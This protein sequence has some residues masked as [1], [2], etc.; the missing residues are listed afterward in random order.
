MKAARR[1]DIG[2]SPLSGTVL[3]EASAGTGKTYAIS[4][5]YLRL[6]I[7]KRLEVEN[8][9]VVTFTVA[10]TGELREQLRGRLRATLSLMDNP[11]GDGC[12][13]ELLG[14]R[15]KYAED[16]LQIALG[17]KFS[18]DPDARERLSRAIRNF[19]EASIFTIHSFCQRALLENA[20]ESGALFEA[21]FI[22]GD[23][24]LLA[25]ISEDYYRKNFYEAPLP[26][27]RYSLDEKLSPESLASLV[28]KRPLDPGYILKGGEGGADDKEVLEAADRLYEKY[29]EINEAWMEAKAEAED[30]LCHCRNE[31]VLNGVSYSSKIITRLLENMDAYA[32]QGEPLP[33]FKD[34][35]KLKASSISNRF[36]R[37][38]SA[39]IPEIF[40]KIG[41]FL[42]CHERAIGVFAGCLLRLQREFFAYAS[43]EMRR[44]KE[45]LAVRS[46][47]DLLV[48]THRA[49]AAGS[50]SALARS[51]RR[52]YAAALI[53]EF[54]DTDPIQY[55][56]FT[57][58][59]G[60]GESLLYLIGDPKQAIYGFR[61]ADIF[62]YMKAAASAGTKS[63]MDVNYRSEPELVEA[64]NTI[65]SN[66]DRPFVFP[67]IGFTRV[68]AAADKKNRG[69]SESAR[70][71]SGPSP[72]MKLWFVPQLP[73]SAGNKPMSKAEAGRIV[74]NAVSAEIVRLISEEKCE[75]GDIAVLVRTGLQARE[76]QAALRI[77]GVPSV[78]YGSE[79]VFASNEA[80]ELLRLLRAVDNPADGRLLRA[81]LA[82]DIMG[83]SGDDIARLISGGDEWE[84]LVGRFFDYRETWARSG[85]IRMYSG[86]LRAEGVRGRLLRRPDGER[87]MTNLQ[88]LAELVHRAEREE[89]L[90]MEGLVK[91]LNRAI[92]EPKET[93]GNEEHELRLETDEKAVTLITIHK[94]KGLQFEIVF[95]PY[96]WDTRE[97]DEPFI[98]HDPSC[99][100]RPVF[101]L[102]GGE[103]DTDE[104]FNAASRERLAE[105]LR[106]FYVALT[107]AKRRCYLA[108]GRINK[109]FSS[110]PAYLF[111]NPGD[112]GD[113]GVAAKLEAYVKNLEE[114]SMLKQ[115]ESLAQKSGG[116][117]E[118]SK[119]PVEAPGNYKTPGKKPASLSYRSFTGSIA[120]GRRVTSFSALSEGSPLERD[121]DFEYAPAAGQ[122][123]TAT[124]NIFTFP[125]GAAAG[126]C[127]HAIFEE[128]DFS[129]SGDVE[130]LIKEKLRLY[131]FESDWA[132]A[133][134]EMVSSVLGTGLSDNTERQPRPL[135]G[136]S[137]EERLH[138]L[139][140]TLPIALVTPEGLSAAFAGA[141]RG[142]PVSDFADSIAHLG[143][144]PVGGFLRGF[145]DMVFVG[146]GRYYLLD[147][148]SNHLGDSPS[149]YSAD[150]IA[151]EMLR[152]RY[153]LQYHLYSVAL[154][155]HLKLRIRDYEYGK[156]FGGVY[157]LFVRGMDPKDESC[158]G[159]FFDLPE[160]RLIESLGRYFDTGDAGP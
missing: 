145:I 41:E 112:L 113:A 9:L 133:L 98:Y 71:E 119:I 89:G 141:G 40:T 136:L 31:G 122:P 93:I 76:M 22:A 72:K 8:I 144:Q 107:R 18:K 26:F 116:A 143:F 131:G 103:E 134:L 23:E 35:K 42:E 4:G 85:F 156:H 20:F 146:D 11:S 17:E 27:V 120:P 63:T 97:V 70:G 110:A 64:V 74:M 86:L 126:S 135:A 151:E 10:A 127:I 53:D 139:E 158:P 147:W 83:K 25:E 21:E 109:S 153:T 39:D 6:I 29:R 124:R 69:D 115:L 54:Q 142:G 57:T 49:L 24:R 7:E 28:K 13:R 33:V 137:P 75:P 55:S 66:V 128:I 14:L 157:Y 155:R 123:E 43:E 30:F 51:V 77:L 47:N 121:Y 48:D 105:D 150:R 140:F 108:W 32:G 88:H 5:L 154:H 37:G 92:A 132:G 118:L 130:G 38:K 117:I 44:R 149:D 58:I 90:G 2:K 79:S 46:F 45:R 100:N 78:L 160:E 82:T 148:K 68:S 159:V 52:R 60:G 62:A 3:I 73:D 59:F 99:E 152:H 91:W 106:L 129:M 19:D 34:I 96:P 138:E 65:F 95:C 104:A 67:Q 36:N 84:A 87:M 16:P 102:G 94:S 15:S 125:R 1:F 12:S 114:E 50:D 101:R 61:G 56:I 111:H 80:V 81:A